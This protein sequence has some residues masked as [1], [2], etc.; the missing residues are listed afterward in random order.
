MKAYAQPFAVLAVCASLCAR[1]EVVDRI[2]AVVNND[3]ISL[4]EVELHAGPELA[5]VNT[6]ANPHDRGEA[7]KKILTEALDSLI[8]EKLLEGEMKDLSIEVGDTEVD[9]G[10][11]DV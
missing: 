10:M 5:R 7:R 11:E 4:S 8:G 6:I 1:A 2:A 9:L 3:I